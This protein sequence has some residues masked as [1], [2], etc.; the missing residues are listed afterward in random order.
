MNL[1]NELQVSAERDDVL[2]V[3]RKMKRLASKLGRRDI[4]DWLQNE[5]GGYSGNVDV[6]AYRKIGTSLA[7]NTNGYVP[8][9]F[10]RIKRGIE[11][12]HFSSLTFPVSIRE[13]ISGVLSWIDAIRAGNAVYLP[14]DRGTEYNR[15]IR[16]VLIIDP[17]FSNQISFLLR[18]D[19]TQ[20]LAIPDLIKNKVLDW[21]CDLEAAGVTG[22]GMSFSEEQK[23]IA[24]SIT[25][26][27]RNSQIEQLN[28][29]GTNQRGD[30]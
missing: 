14:I 3:L 12:L 6:P 21:A 4:A 11:D 25:F 15:A 2:T 22:E 19:E 24:H 26:N 20:L 13:P 29:L 28:N 30:K 27:I 16:S 17:E 8:A 10:G 23:A 5:Q 7:Y 1:V 9:G 18:L